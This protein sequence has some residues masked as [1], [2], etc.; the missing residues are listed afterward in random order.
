MPKVVAFEIP[1][2][3]CWFWSDDHDPPHFHVKKKGKWEMRVKFLLTDHDMFELVW[4]DKPSGKE[5]R[6]L[7]TVVTANLTQLLAE[8]EENVIQ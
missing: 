4:G 7:R 6:H 8:W 5:L 2:L 1:G 3:S